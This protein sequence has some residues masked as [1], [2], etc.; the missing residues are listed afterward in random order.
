MLQLLEQNCLF[1]QQIV[2]QLLADLCIC[3]VGRRDDQ[4]DIAGVQIIELA[5]IDDQAPADLAGTDQVHFI[6]GDVRVA[7]RRGPEQRGK[8][9]DIPFTAAKRTQRTAVAQRWIDLERV[10]KRVADS[11][12][13]ELAVKQ[14]DGGIGR[15]DHRQGQTVRGPDNNRW[16]I[17]DWILCGRLAVR[18]RPGGQDVPQ[19]RGAPPDSG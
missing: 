13:R 1:A 7:R 2:L 5:G 14:Q 16:D 17:H 3:D 18:K 19:A 9:G 10:A 11:D 4:P 12:D 8:L 15:G 6:G